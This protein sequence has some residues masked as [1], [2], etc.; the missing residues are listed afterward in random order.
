MKRKRK[1]NLISIIFFFRSGQKK[2]LGNL[3]RCR[4]LAI[5]LNKY[6]NINIIISTT[7]KK[8]FDIGFKGF[9]FSW[10]PID[11]IMKSKDNDII[12]VDISNCPINL[13]NRLKSRCKFLVGIDDWGTGPF[14]YDF[15]LRPNPIKLPQPKMM[16]KACNIYK[17]K[18]HILLN[19]KFAKLKIRKFNRNVKNVFVCFGGSDPRGYTIRVMRI[20]LKENFT[21]KI[22]FTV[23]I[24]PYFLSVNKLN[25][26]L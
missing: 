2:G 9:D 7:H 12:I 6:K 14:V 25:N 10:M 21:K 18:D 26:M 22:K 17:G 13:Q 19:P 24:G 20:L 11:R 5:E 15:F 16:E 8:L 4:S 1:D 3:Y 23:V